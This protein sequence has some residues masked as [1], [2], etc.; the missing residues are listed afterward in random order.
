MSIKTTTF[1]D[2]KF[3]AAVEGADESC[4]DRYIVREE[5]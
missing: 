5:P 1:S 2:S 3:L 4:P